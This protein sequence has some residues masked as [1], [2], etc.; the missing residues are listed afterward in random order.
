[1]TDSITPNNVTQPA[2]LPP[3]MIGRR[4]RDITR[5]SL[6]ALEFAN[7]PPLY[8]V[9]GGD[10]VRFRFDEHDRPLLE[11][12]NDAMMYCRLVR[13]A[14]FFT[15]GNHGE[16]IPRDPPL[17]VARDVLA[18]GNWPLPPIEG[19]V[20]APILRTDG[21]IVTEQGYDTP[22]CLYYFPAPGFEMDPV[23]ESPTDGDVEKARK[24]L[25]EVLQ[26]FPFK[27][28]GSLTNMIGL[29]IT[30]IVR[31]IIKGCIPLA[32]INAPQAGTG[33]TMLGHVIAQIASGHDASLLPYSVDSEEMRKKITS[34]LLAGAN[35]IV[36]DNITTELD[37]EVVAS[38][39]TTS[40]W[41]DRLLGRNKLLRLPQRAVWIANGNNLKIGSDLPRRCFA[42]NLDAEMSQPW[43]RDNFQHPN[44]LEWV[45]EIR[46]EL[47]WSV[48]VLVRRWKTAGKPEFSG[49]V[50]GGFTQ[51]CRVVGGILETAGIKGFLSNF[52]SLY[53]SIDEEGSQW[54]AFLLALRECFQDKR[55]STAQISD[56]LTY[57]PA[58]VEALPDEL[59]SPF[60]YDG[61]I[62]HHVKQ[63]LGIEL[64]RRVHTRYG[65]QQLYL[66]HEQDRHL[67]IATWQVVCGEAGI[68]GD[69]GTDIQI[70]D[71][72]QKVEFEVPA[73]PAVPAVLEE[74]CTACGG[75]NWHAY[76]DG[77]GRFC[78]ICHPDP[79]RKE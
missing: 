40:E 58:L 68:C 56:A 69:S 73:V 70:E 20:E 2:G 34:A 21:S 55:F 67:K 10:V 16:V 61:G 41:G 33:K 24:M 8:F 39:L 47:I 50:L 19:I 59:G 31:P 13:V 35:V 54:E 37:S 42:I 75:S 15:I 9:R 45:A 53:N 7:H 29:L 27:E 77:S 25:L 14:D 74:R 28:D 62:D 78:G 36:M 72:N 38:A 44:L 43:K 23:P 49:T 12:V 11:L 1:M 46:A 60:R 51:W 6:Q 52:D 18:L 48:F 26:D 65:S 76:P 71:L 32:L 5:D 64:R 63:K 22:T 4:L 3:I 66:E 79:A 17:K 57:D 30:P